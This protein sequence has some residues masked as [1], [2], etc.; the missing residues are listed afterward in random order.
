MVGGKS[1]KRVN[2]RTKIARKQQAQHTGAAGDQPVLSPSPP[3]DS[4]EHFAQHPPR[5]TNAPFGHPEEDRQTVLQIREALRQRQGRTSRAP[6]AA[7]AAE[8]PAPATRAVKAKER[9]SSSKRQAAK[10]ESKKNSAPAAAAVAKTTH[11]AARRRAAVRERRRFLL[12]Q[13]SS[14]EAR[15]ATAQ[16]ELQLFDKVQT[17]PAYAADPF[18]AVMQHLS[19]TMNTLKPQTPDVGRAA[20]E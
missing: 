11:S 3:V 6:A 14:A 18:A 20:R 10:K 2:L 9:K 4:A 15:M 12:P 8:T 19:A 5:S 1:T 17:V 7:T 16:E 13:L